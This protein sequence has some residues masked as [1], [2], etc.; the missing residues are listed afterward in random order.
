LK[1]YILTTYTVSDWEEIEAETPE[2]AARQSDNLLSLCHQCSKEY[3]EGDPISIQVF[4]D[5][6]EEPVFSEEL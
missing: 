5:P 4:E 1:Y 3:N 6:S 2:D